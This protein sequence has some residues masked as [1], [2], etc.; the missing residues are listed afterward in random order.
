MSR[1]TT[2]L[3]V[4]FI[5]GLLALNLSGCVPLIVG[6]AAGAGGVVFVKGMLSKNFD[7]PV[8]GVY[9]ASMKGLKSLKYSIYADKLKL[10]AAYIRAED[11]SG[12]KIYVDIS[13]LTEKASKIRI[14]A[15]IIGDEL[16]SQAILNAIEKYL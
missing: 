4:I 1:K 16:Q 6:A 5:T 3:G 9:Q 11:A 7:V 10:H 2:N 8:K 15:G 13:A 12:K 14:R